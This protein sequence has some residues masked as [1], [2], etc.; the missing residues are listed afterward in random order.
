MA[1]CLFRWGGGQ[2]LVDVEGG[3]IADLIFRAIQEMDIDNRMLV[4]PPTRLSLLGSRVSLS[5]S[6]S[7]AIIT[8]LI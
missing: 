6:R 8:P 1:G 2:E 7:T 5:V 4:S 3:G